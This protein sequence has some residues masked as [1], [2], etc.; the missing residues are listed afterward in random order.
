MERVLPRGYRSLSSLNTKLLVDH[1]WGKSEQLHLLVLIR[2]VERLLR[3]LC[4]HI[5]YILLLSLCCVEG[6]N[7][8]LHVAMC[9][10]VSLISF[11]GDWKKRPTRI[12]SWKLPVSWRPRVRFFSSN[13]KMSI[14]V[15]A[16]PRDL[17]GFTCYFSGQAIIFPPEESRTMGPKVTFAVLPS[18]VELHFISVHE[19]VD[20]T[21]YTPPR[22]QEN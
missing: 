20:L 4:F 3:L 2:Q 11:G 8:D 6:N 12:S 17:W 1:L 9:I 13:P 10:S 14:F 22:K 18:M 15:N 16:V 19:R 5:I 21:S 7:K